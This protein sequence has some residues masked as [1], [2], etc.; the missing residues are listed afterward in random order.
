MSFSCLFLVRFWVSHLAVGFHGTTLQEGCNFLLQ[1]VVLTFPATQ[2]YHADMLLLCHTSQGQWALESE[3]QGR[4]HCYPGL[5]VHE[6]A[7]HQLIL[8]QASQ[9]SWTPSRAVKVSSQF[10]CW[11]ALDF[12][13]PKATCEIG[14]PAWG[15]KFFQSCSSTKFKGHSLEDQQRWLSRMQLWWYFGKPGWWEAQQHVT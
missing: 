4:R 15:C 12:A 3:G 8:Q 2:L 14:D 7:C 6:L 9:L 10:C 5:L 11:L 13:W 1:Q